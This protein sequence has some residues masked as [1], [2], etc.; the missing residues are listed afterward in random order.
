VLTSRNPV[1][2]LAD[3]IRRFGFT[4]PVLIDRTNTMLAGYGR[5]E[6]ARLIGCPRLPAVGSRG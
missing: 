3:S 6:A 2:Q 5:V 4:N 1:R